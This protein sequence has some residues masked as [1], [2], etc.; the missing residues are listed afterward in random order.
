[1]IYSKRTL[2]KKKNHQWIIVGILSVTIGILNIL[3]V[4]IGYFQTPYGYSYLAVG[5]YYQDYFQYTQQI[6]QGMFG[7]WLVQ[8]Q[9]TTHDPTRTLIGWEQYIFIGKFA[10]LFHLSPFAAYWISIFLFSI[11]LCFLL[12]LVIRRM[13]KDK[14][15]FLQISAFLFCL[16]AVPFIKIVQNNGQWKIVTFDFWYAPISLFHRIGGIPHH[17]TITIFVL[18]AMFLTD[19][20]LTNLYTEKVQKLLIKTVL[21]II[22]L[23]L[24][25]TFGP[26]QVIN[27]LSS[28]SVVSIILLWKFFIK[29]KKSARGIRLIVFLS[30]V[31]LSVLPAALYIKQSH[32]S[33]E[34]F[35]WVMAWEVAQQNYPPVYLV[36]LTIGPILLF[37]PFGIRQYFKSATSMRLLVFFLAAS[38]Y[39][40]ASTPFGKY[41][42]TFNLRFLTPLSYVLFGVLAVLGIQAIV[43]RLPYKKIVMQ[44][45]V[46]GFLL[47]AITVTLV[48]L[49]SFGGVEPISYQPNELL[50]GIKILNQQ[51]DQRAVLTSPS[52]S[53][54]MIVPSIV[55]RNVYLGRMFL[56]PNYEEKIGISDRFYQGTMTPE[57]GKLLLLDNSIGYVLLSTTEP[58]PL[59]NLQKYP[60]L[61]EMYKN[62]SLFIF[63]FE[64]DSGS[65]PE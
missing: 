27:F 19:H 17:F 62:N 15:F 56:T 2:M 8:N 41:L 55:D 12:F 52:Q 49:Q 14:P 6:A 40:F 36:L 1:M 31:F 11:L 5:H 44:T 61:K 57:A 50:E 24:L 45:L 34:L 22:I 32:Q 54:G 18:V 29:E 53:L 43:Q 26:L 64:M 59:S 42:G 20:I 23:I 46:F 28:L 37:V 9:F 13:T 38:S 16:F 30:A 60:F 21:L 63:R 65:R 58:Y 4:I 48:I 51:R 25:L 3:R 10:L 47:Y 33:E 35:K 39:V 7:H